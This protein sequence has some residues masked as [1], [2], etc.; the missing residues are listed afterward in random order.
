[1]APASSCEGGRII[2]GVK[3]VE[4]AAESTGLAVLSVRVVRGDNSRR[5][6]DGEVQGKRE[7]AAQSVRFKCREITGDIKFSRGM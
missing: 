5:Q 1:M 4:R 7:N 3:D 6:R 2:E